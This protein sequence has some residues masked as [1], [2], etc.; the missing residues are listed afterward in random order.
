MLENEGNSLLFYAF[1][2]ANK[3]GKTGLAVTVDVW[4]ITRAGV[5]TEIVAGAA[6]TEIGDGLYRYLLAAAAVDEPAEY[7]AVFKTAD[8]TVDQRDLT[9][10]YEIDRAGLER[11]ALVSAGAIAV[12]SPITAGGNVVTYRGDSY[13]NADGRA[14]EWQDADFPTL[15]G[16]TITVVIDDVATFAGS[17][18]AADTAR[19]ELTA[20]QT[21]TIPR[22]RHHF[23]VRATLGNMVATLVDAS[24]ISRDHTE[25]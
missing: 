1:Y 11:L 23:Q 3:V 8:V 10:I 12:T 7:I 25:V 17:V 2:V 21:A 15:T 6:A 5:A 24:W 4:E 16:A 18:P 19:L 14:L 9:C 20:A 22:D 13:R